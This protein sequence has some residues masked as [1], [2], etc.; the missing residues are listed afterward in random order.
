MFIDGDE[1]YIQSYKG[2]SSDGC[3]ITRDDDYPE[4]C[5]GFLGLGNCPTGNALSNAFKANV[6]PGDEGVDDFC[7]VAFDDSNQE[8]DVICGSETSTIF[9]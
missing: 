2:C 6:F 9:F 7:V 3:T 5:V 1:W 4:T 8:L